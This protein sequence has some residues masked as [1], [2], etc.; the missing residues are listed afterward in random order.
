VAGVALS[1]DPAL[2]LLH[3]ALNVAARS[4]AITVLF[5]KTP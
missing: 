5:K 1:F 2:S 4:E 3:A